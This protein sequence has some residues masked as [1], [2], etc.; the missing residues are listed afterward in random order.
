[1]DDADL[2][3]KFRCEYCGQKFSVHKNNAGNKGRCPKCKKIIVIPTA[4]PQISPSN[5]TGQGAV[6]VLAES[7]SYNSALLDLQQ[8]DETQGLTSVDSDG[9]SQTC[10][11]NHQA[12]EEDVQETESSNRLPWYADIFLYPISASGLVNIAILSFLPRMLPPLGHL[13]YW[14]QPSPSVAIIVVLTG[15]S[16]YCLSDYIRDSTGGSR[17]APEIDISL[18]ALFNAWELIWPILSTFI[19]I[20]VCAVPLLVYLISTGKADIIFWLLVTYGVLFLPMVLMAVT[21]F[22]SLRALNPILIIA[23]MIN[24]FLPYSGLVL[25]FFAVCG[26]VAVILI[27]MPQSFIIS[28]ILGTVCIY[29]AIVMSHVLGRFCYQYKERLNWDV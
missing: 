6:K 15:Y 1:M 12:E 29:L 19:C 13:K 24:V 26:I 4:R 22:D 20:A 23:S 18:S 28:Y 25:L 10:E 7:T 11:Y 16:L 17:R 14:I 5:Q 9:P 27:I 3:I 8:K 21:L 2:I